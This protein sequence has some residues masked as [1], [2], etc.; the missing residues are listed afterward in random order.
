[1]YNPEGTYDPEESEG[2]FEFSNDDVEPAGCS[3]SFGALFVKKI[4]RLFFF[5]R[6]KIL[7]RFL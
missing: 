7:F 1:M 4:C 2:F 5:L 3:S 6:V